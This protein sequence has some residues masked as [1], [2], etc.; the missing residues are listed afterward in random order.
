MSRRTYRL[1]FARNGRHFETIFIKSRLY[2]NCI[3]PDST[4]F[5]AGCP[6]QITGVYR[7]ECG[8]RTSSVAIVAVIILWLC[9]G[10]GG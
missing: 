4:R 8:A 2:L 7:L 10:I 1:A 6:L 5:P 3:A 9:A